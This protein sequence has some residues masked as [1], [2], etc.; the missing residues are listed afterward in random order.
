MG[1]ST[2]DSTWVAASQPFQTNL[3]HIISEGTTFF[4]GA[5]TATSPPIYPWHRDQSPDYY[6]A[7][8]TTTLHEAGHS[9]G[10]YEASSPYAIRQTVMNPFLG[11]NDS[12]HFGPTSVQDCDNNMVDSQIGYANNC[13]IAGGGGPPDCSTITCGP[14]AILPLEDP[15][16]QLCCGTS[17]ILIDIA[18]NGFDLTDAPGGVRFD[19]NVDGATEQ[20]SWTSADS[21]DVFLCLDRNGNGIIDNGA[22]LFGNHTPQPA[23]TIPNG[24]LA[25]A[26]YDKASIG[27]NADERID[28]LDAIFSSLRL[29]H[30]NNHNGVSESAELHRLPEL[31]VAAINLRFKESKRTDQYGNRFRYRAKA[32][33]GQGAH[34]GR[35]AWDVFFVRN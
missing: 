23:S 16:Y 22:E 26:E 17:P 21:D 35:W 1:F 10:L 33:D 31:G 18:G 13:L 28:S 8:L 14:N 29:W 11:I 5:H 12:G 20:L 4:W 7:V 9:M 3:G 34:V 30:D 19:I 24:F 25:L 6:R 32:Y 2:V 27:G 15:D